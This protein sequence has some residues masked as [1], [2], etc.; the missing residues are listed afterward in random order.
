MTELQH[1][2]TQPDLYERLIDRLGLALETARTAV[3][4]R[5]EHP[6]ELELRG[7]SY[8]EFQF[9]EAYLDRNEVAS[10][11]VSIAWKGNSSAS[12]ELAESVAPPRP[13]AKV[14]WL[15]DQKRASVSSKLSR[16]T[17]SKHFKH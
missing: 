7:L 3:R 5:N 10:E 14:I 12:R 11:P 4:L 2:A 17:S 16:Y 15:R 1:T 8:A 6:A 13:L 9:I